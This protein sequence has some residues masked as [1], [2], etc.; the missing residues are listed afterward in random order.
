MNLIPVEN[1]ILFSSD[2]Q[3]GAINRSADGSSFEVQFD[4]PISIPKDAMNVSLSIE[5]ATVWFTVPNIVETNNRLFI[6]GDDTLGNP[7]LF[8]VI[9]PKGLYDL[10][11]LNN[12]VLIQLEN[13]GAKTEPS[14]LINFLSDANTQKVIIRFNYD[15]VFVDFSQPNTPRDILGFLPLQIGA[16]AT[17]P[18]NV[19][20]DNV[21]Q[22]NT[23]NYFLIATDLVREGIRFNN[24]HAGIVSQVLIDVPPGSQI[25]SKP[26]NP[27]RI[28]ADELIGAKRTNIRFN[29]TDDRLRPVDTNSE[30][31]SLRMVIRYL[32]PV[33]LQK[34]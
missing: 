5:E 15:N 11:G 10:P 3:L 1:S 22:F 19:I 12:A 31:Y 8:T 7:Q 34:S 32:I 14:P 20:A 16:F 25:V 23:V 17:V 24:R 18:I 13:L 30:Y 6:F 28:N 9:V 2:D 4:T 29:L 21:A 26:F 33:V 27:P